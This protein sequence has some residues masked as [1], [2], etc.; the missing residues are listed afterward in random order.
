MSR[1]VLASRN[2]GALLDRLLTQPDIVQRVQALDPPLLARLIRRVGLEDA[3]ELV[4]MATTVQLERVFDEDLW[5]SEEPGLAERFDAERFGLWLEVMLEAGPAFA[6]RR[7]LELDEELLTFALSQQVLVIDIE[8]LAIGMSS[9]ERSDDDDQLD[10]QF[11]SSLYHELEQYRVIARDPR[12]WEAVLSVLLEL[13]EQ[14]YPALQ[15]LLA[16]CCELS[17]SYIEDN[18]GLYDVLS[19][20]E[21]LFEDVAGEREQRRE[22]LGYVAPQA[23]VSFLALACDQSEQEILHAQGRDPITRSYLRATEVASAARSAAA[24]PGRSEPESRTLAPHASGE[25]SALSE[26]LHEE[27]HVPRRL[28]GKAPRWL[29]RAMQEL[30]ARDLPLHTTRMLELSYLA[31]V[32]LAGCSLAGRALRPVEAAEAAAQLCELGATR[33]AKLT[34]DRRVL[35]VAALAEHDLIKLFW[36]GFRDFEARAQQGKARSSTLAPP[37][38]GLRW[39]RATASKQG[40]SG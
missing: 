8:A 34:L 13:N 38:A 22:Q 27:A 25:H 36:L 18:G 12:S 28:A 26:L 32:L 15:R 16:R 21:T 14:H 31:N 3:G 19:A 9:S 6:A 30:L 7:L 17:S 10:K 4:A 20:Q 33:L 23:A 37:L 2:T 40:R 39:K 35:P 5:R 1:T 24:A 29:A 11:E